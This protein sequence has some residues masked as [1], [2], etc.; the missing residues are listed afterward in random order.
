M[1]DTID[2]T[3]FMAFLESLGLP[4]E[5]IRTFRV[6]GTGSHLA[7]EAEVYAIDSGGRRYAVEGEDGKPHAATHKVCI[8][9][10]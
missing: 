10:V 6:C 8:P 7:I 1:P 9:V 3:A 5:Q 4:L 2:R